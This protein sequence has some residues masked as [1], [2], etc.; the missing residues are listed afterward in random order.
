[1][2][3]V[4]NLRAMLVLDEE[5]HFGR[6]ALRAGMSQPRLSSIVK[7]FELVAGARLFERRPVVCPT[8]AG[9]VLLT[10]IKRSLDSLQWGFKEAEL[11]GSGQIGSLSVGFPTWLMTT[12]V[13]EVVGKFRAD[14]PGVEIVLHELSSA[15]QL[16]GIREGRLQLGFFREQVEGEAEFSVQPLLHEKWIGAVP[17][18]HPLKRSARVRDFADESFI[19]FPRQLAPSLHAQFTAVCVRAGFTP[20]VIQEAQEWLTIL[21]LVRAGGGVAFVPSSLTSL[22][23]PGIRYVEISDS[24]QGI[25][26]SLCR[27]RIA[28]EATIRLVDRLVERAQAL[29]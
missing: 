4:R 15:D 26:L 2:M 29:Q 6:A 20:K 5:R 16:Q 12:F 13:P 24:R 17:A 14:N 27:Q 1:M 19:A 9:S 23:L 7:E 22:V 25:Q 11:I 3:E 8:A 21:A 28:D 18:A 10:H